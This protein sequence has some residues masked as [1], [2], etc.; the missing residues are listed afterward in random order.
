MLVDQV[1]YVNFCTAWCKGTFVTFASRQNAV[2][3]TEVVDVV[4]NPLH[5]VYHRQILAA[6]QTV[7]SL[8]GP[9]PFWQHLLQSILCGR[10]DL[11]VVIVQE[12]FGYQLMFKAQ[13]FKEPESG[14]YIYI[15]SKIRG[16]Y[17]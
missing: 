4:F 3:R 9:Q 6:H 12:Q 16:K 10:L 11:D 14:I 7:S 1:K 17:G 2:E 13:M 5:P 15:F 8:D